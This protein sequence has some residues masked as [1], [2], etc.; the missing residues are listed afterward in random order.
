MTDFLSL[1]TPTLFSVS[2]FAS[3]NSPLN[4]EQFVLR[5]L[6]CCSKLFIALLELFEIIR[7]T[8]GPLFQLDIEDQRVIFGYLISFVLCV[9][10]TIV[11]AVVYGFSRTRIGRLF[12]LCS[13]F[14]AIF[15]AVVFVIAWFIAEDNLVW[16]VISIFFDK[17]NI[18]R[19]L[20]G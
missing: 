5:S 3:G 2:R 10:S 7:P 9:V 12:F 8:S 6:L 4:L 11:L 1:V 19:K 17:N 20:F 16:L 13:I 15:S 14:F 18:V